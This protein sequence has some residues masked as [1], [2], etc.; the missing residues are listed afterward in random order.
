[1]RSVADA[2]AWEIASIV[3][4]LSPA[5]AAEALAEHADE[6]HRLGIAPED[7]VAELLA[8]GRLLKCRD[9]QSARGALDAAVV[10]YVGRV[11]GELTDR[12][13]RDPLTGILNHAA[14][15]ARVADETART[16]RYG[17][18][19][20][21]VLFDVDH[22]KETNDRNGH[23]EGDRLLRVL[24]GALTHTSRETDVVGR[25]GGDEFA[26]LLLEAEEQ[27]LAAF[28]DRLYR[29][30]PSELGVSAGA[31]F[32]PDESSSVDE[33]IALADRR[34]YARKAARAA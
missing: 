27:R 26:A 31:A 32:L 18:R 9:S 28:L 23:Q 5:E 1:V 19:L 33:L 22:F 11:T 8:L 12:A 20:A 2:S 10:G 15:H 34:L 16:R 7:V 3:A 25:V 21:L 24:A 14:F 13:Q 17:G 30:L 6:R 29:R 4:S